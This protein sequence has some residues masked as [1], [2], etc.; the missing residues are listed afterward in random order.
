MTATEALRLKRKEILRLA[1]S[2]CASNLRL[3]GSP[4]RSDLD[5]LLELLPEASLLDLIALKQ[6]KEEHTGCRVDLLTP[7][8]ISP[9]I[10]NRV[11]AEVR[12]L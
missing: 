12:P 11:L 9:Y 7:D 2:R 10:R 6:D 1:R 4:T 3:F 8:S 5:I